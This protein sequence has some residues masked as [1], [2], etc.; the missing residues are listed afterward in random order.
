MERVIRKDNREDDPCLRRMFDMSE[1]VP[2]VYG[3]YLH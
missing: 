1:E 2:T 3:Y